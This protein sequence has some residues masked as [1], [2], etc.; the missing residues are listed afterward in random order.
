MAECK[1]GAKYLTSIP[2]TKANKNR[3]IKKE[4]EKLAYTVK[5][6]KKM[7]FHPQDST[8]RRHENRSDAQD[9]KTQT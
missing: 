3:N 6:K 2:Q 7:V 8:F 1:S 4:K 9:K 5:Y